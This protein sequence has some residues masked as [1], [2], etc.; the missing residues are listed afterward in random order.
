ML[1]NYS[2]SM[3]AY[4]LTNADLATP[5]TQLDLSVLGLGVDTPTFAKMSNLARKAKNAAYSLIATAKGFGK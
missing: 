2:I 4:N 3:R 5:A 1:Y